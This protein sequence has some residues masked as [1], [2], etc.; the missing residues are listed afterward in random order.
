M[1]VRCYFM[2]DGRIVS[3]DEIENC[4]SDADAIAQARKFFEG[5]KERFDG[6]EVWELARVVGVY[7][8]H[9]DQTRGDSP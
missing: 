5:R 2:R 8:V 1:D 4:A 9:S 6:F 7:S 3:F